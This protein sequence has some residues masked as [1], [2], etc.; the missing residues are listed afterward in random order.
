MCDELLSHACRLLSSSLFS[1]HVS[2]VLRG[3]LYACRKRATH[4]WSTI[5]KTT[6]SATLFD[7]RRCYHFRLALVS[8]R[9]KTAN[10]AIIFKL[11]TCEYCPMFKQLVT[12]RTN[13][14]VRLKLCHVSGF[15]DD[16]AVVPTRI[17]LP[18]CSPHLNHEHV[19]R[20]GVEV[21][22]LN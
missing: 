4:W 1:V 19:S 7:C 16:S 10:A 15:L 18:T 9:E 3:V 2:Y 12:F 11:Q 5:R 22:E 21:E 14:C 17:D 6:W 20:P 13:A 8:D